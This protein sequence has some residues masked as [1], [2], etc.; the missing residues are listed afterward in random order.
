MGENLPGPNDTVP[1]GLP[2]CIVPWYAYILIRQSVVP[3]RRQLAHRALTHRDMQQ[4]Q[5]SPAAAPVA[6]ASVQVSVRL[7]LSLRPGRDCKIHFPD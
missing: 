4:R 1:V 6:V 5:K 2:V 3:C 7:A